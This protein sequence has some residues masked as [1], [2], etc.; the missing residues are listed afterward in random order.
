MGF[1]AKHFEIVSTVK[2]GMTIEKIKS[3]LADMPCRFAYVLH[4]KDVLETGD[5]KEPHWH[6]YIN[7]GQTSWNSDNVAKRFNVA[8]NFVSKVK[9]KSGDML[10]YL[11]HQNAPEK[12]QYPEEDVI[13]NYDWKA[14]KEKT[15]TKRGN[16]KRADEIRDNIVNGEWRDYNI[17]MHVTPKE[18]YLHDRVIKSAFE[19][20]ARKLRGANRVMQA[21][22]IYGDSG[23]GK[24]TLAKMMAEE[25]KM[26][27][28]V[29]SGSNDV[30]D[31][32]KGEDCIILDDLRPSCMGLSD[33]L[34]MLDPN[35]SS[36][37]KSRYKNKVLECKMIIITTTL[38]IETFFHKV[39]ESDNETAIQLQRR[40][41]S[42][43]YLTS[44]T[45]TP[46]LWLKKSRR[47]REYPSQP[48][49]VIAKFGLEDFTLEEGEAFIND[50][51]GSL[52]ST[53]TQVFNDI[54]A[55]EF[56]PYHPKED[57]F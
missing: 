26:S 30:L 46:Y 28:Y 6:I 8:E 45:M 13:S 38:P 27:I 3:V 18:F 56:E 37:V 31:D 54:R 32:Y 50:L 16:E 48:N 14:D 10:A 22:Y 7:F 21:I 25:K 39:F 43:F 55:G 2:S 49:P 15:L 20:R 5:A 33:L 44:K 19:F 53:T 4:D 51:L 12:H 40:C 11:T 52:S 1:S 34:K 36:T 42:L 41:E 17:H 23:T 24:T 29:S 57:I 9:G 47:Y 35:T